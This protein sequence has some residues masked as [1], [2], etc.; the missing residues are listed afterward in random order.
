MLYIEN[1]QLEDIDLAHLGP[2][3]SRGKNRPI[4]DE[5]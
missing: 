3:L 1:L 2:C 4:F 5:R